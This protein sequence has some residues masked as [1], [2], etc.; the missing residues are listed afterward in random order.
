MNE[1]M[2]PDTRGRLREALAAI[3]ATDKLGQL[4]IAA[5]RLREIMLDAGV[6]AEAI[7]PDE[8]PK[9]IPVTIKPL[10][11]FSIPSMPPDYPV[12][13]DITQ[14]NYGLPSKVARWLL[15]NRKQELNG[16]ERQFL[17][18]MDTKLMNG[19]SLSLGMTHKIDEIVRQVPKKKAGGAR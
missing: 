11:G 16:W 9:P 13:I 15:D 6:T 1:T 17:A 19:A 18:D 4:G 7:L 2:T 8:K 5:R 10:A 14:K 3:L 12:G